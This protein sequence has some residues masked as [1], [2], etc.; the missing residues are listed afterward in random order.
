MNFQTYSDSDLQG[1]IEKSRTH[2]RLRAAKIFQEPSNSKYQTLF[3]AMQPESYLPP[4]AHYHPEVWM[5]IRGW[6]L[7]GTF[8]ESGEIREV[9]SLTK[10]GTVYAEIPAH[11]Y[12]TAISMDKDSVFMNV[13]PGP[14]DK[15]N[16]KISA[17][18]APQEDS[19][20]TEDQWRNYFEDM[21]NRI[22]RIYCN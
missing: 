11:V 6:F 2:P 12:H 17:P 3:N 9:L 14:Y 22:I 7:L 21:Q 20:E 5:P 18:W 1:L 8:D 13:N 10:K 4:H 19:A 16:S 15:D